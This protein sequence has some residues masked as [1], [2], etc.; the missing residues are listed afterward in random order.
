MGLAAFV[1]DAFLLHFL[2]SD[3]V[4]KDALARHLV[5]LPFSLVHPAVLEVE[6]SIAV[7]HVLDPLSFVHVAISELHDSVSMAHAIQPLAVVSASVSVLH[8]SEIEWLVVL[9]FAVV[10]VSVLKV[11]GPLSAEPIVVPLAIDALASPQQQLS[12]DGPVVFPLSDKL[13]SVSI[14]ARSDSILFT[15]LEVSHVVCAF[16]LVYQVAF[17]FDPVFIKLASVIDLGYLVHES[18]FSLLEAIMEVPRILASALVGDEGPLAEDFSS[19]ELAHVHILIGELKSAI[20]CIILLRKLDLWGL[21]HRVEIRLVFLVW[22]GVVDWF[23]VVNRLLEKALS[24]SHLLLN[25]VV[26][27]LRR[28]ASEVWFVWSLLSLPLMLVERLGQGL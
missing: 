18:A 27:L 7:P 16:S 22:V 23:A 21:E 26:D 11:D 13:V 12:L 9:P 14:L 8:Y 1:E 17:A 3:D 15:V 4:I 24:S 2:A 25:R 6:D 20:S 28:S 19:N 5:E 10:N